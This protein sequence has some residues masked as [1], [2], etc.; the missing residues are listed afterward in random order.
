M[1]AG[2]QTDRADVNTQVTTQ[3][4]AEPAADRNQRHPQL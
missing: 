3:E 1:T 2:L 4:V